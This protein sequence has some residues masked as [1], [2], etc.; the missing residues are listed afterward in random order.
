LL[1]A[2]STKKTPAAKTRP[3]PGGENRPEPAT[4]T[5]YAQRAARINAPRDVIDDYDEQRWASIRNEAHY[6]AQALSSSD[7]PRELRAFAS[8]EWELARAL[9][10]AALAIA[11]KLSLAHEEMI[12]QLQQVAHAFQLRR[13]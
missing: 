12:P 13:R 11:T 9:M 3:Q 7:L 1:A 2:A 6:L 5:A 8:A 10:G 4:T